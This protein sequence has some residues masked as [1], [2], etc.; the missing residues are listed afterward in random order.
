VWLAYDLEGS[1]EEIPPT[2]IDYAKRDRRWC[3]GNL[4]HLRLALSRGFNAL[5]RLHFSMGVMSYAASPLWLLFLIA[6]GVEAYLQ[7]QQE[8][9]YFF[10]ENWIPVWPV[11]FA[12][13]MTTVLLVTLTML[14]LPKL[15]ALRCCSRKTGCAALMAECGDA[16]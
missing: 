15:L 7:T 14:F 6:T 8:L 3:Q 12:V 1:Y 11:S 9:V 4:Q 5:S 16:T 13:E 2:L 10:G